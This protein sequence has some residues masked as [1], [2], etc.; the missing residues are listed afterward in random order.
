MGLTD[1]REESR[2]GCAALG[3]MLAGFIEAESA[4]HRQAN[5]VG[6]GVF[7]AVVFPPADWAEPKRIWRL[8]RLR[9]AARAAELS[10]HERLHTG[11]DG[12]REV[13]VYVRL[14]SLRG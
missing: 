1:V 8:Q 11:I 12:A 5:F 7:L 3:I 6:I 4:V 13:G 14:R 9:P 2:V 10:M